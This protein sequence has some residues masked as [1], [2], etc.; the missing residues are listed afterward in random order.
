MHNRLL[1]IFLQKNLCKFVCSIQEMYD[2]DRHIRLIQNAIKAKSAPMKVKIVRFVDSN[3][4][5][6]GYK[7]T[8]DIFNFRKNTHIFTT[9]S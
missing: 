5:A 2:L 1:H 8:F 3:A 9:Y 4:Y 7:I 6:R